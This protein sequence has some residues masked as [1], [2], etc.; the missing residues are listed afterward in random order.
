MEQTFYALKM[1]GS[2]VLWGNIDNDFDYES[3]QSSY[4]P[5]LLSEF[6]VKNNRKKIENLSNFEFYELI[7]VTLTI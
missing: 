4:I 6:Y 7:P 2:S 5:H 1:K 3:I